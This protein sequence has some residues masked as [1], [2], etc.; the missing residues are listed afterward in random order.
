MQLDI[1]CRVAAWPRK[2]RK[3]S[4]LTSRLLQARAAP[5]P[6]GLTG[7]AAPALAAGPSSQFDLN[8]DIGKPGVY[9]LFS[10]SALP[11]TTQTVTYKAG[12]TP[13]TDTFTGTGVWTLLNSAGGITAAPGGKNSSLLNYV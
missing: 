5:P 3:L 13:T 4:L 6:I 8:G 12:G 11:A 10:L 9:D 7:A 2:R 1:T